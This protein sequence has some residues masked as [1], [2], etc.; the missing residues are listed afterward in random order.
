MY[1]S[2]YQTLDSWRGLAALL[3][4]FHHVSGMEVGRSAVMVFF[5]ISGYCIT[6]SAYSC[7]ERGLGFWGY[8]RR[9]VRRIY[10]PYLLALAY[11]GVTRLI[12][13]W[14]TGQD[15]LSRIT[16]WQWVQNVTLT[17][18]VSL[19]PSPIPR[20]E[21]NYTNLV[22]AFWSLGYEEQ[23]YLLVAVL[24]GV[25]ARWENG[26]T[27]GLLAITAAAAIWFVG[28]GGL[29][30]GWFLDYWL[31][32][33]MGTLSYWRLCRAAPAQQ[34]WIDGAL[35]AVTLIAG[36][37]LVAEIDAEGRPRSAEVFTA[38]LFALVLIGLRRWDAPLHA[39]SFGRWTGALGLVTY[40]L[41]LIHQCNLTLVHQTILLLTPS[42]CPT[43][44]VIGLK[45]GLHV[46]IAFL[47]WWFCKR[48]FLN[49]PMDG[50]PLVPSGTPVQAQE[51]NVG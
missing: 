50:P 28:W 45:I 13:W 2:R 12:K 32:F 47:F 15:D 29:A 20:A 43:S 6:A 4:V 49:R 7:Q 16:P 36:A 23:F 18:W 38:G 27:R 39:S 17:Q 25:S 41:Y 22:A 1:A 42:G 46:A 40:S 24:V 26:L 3:V 33:G 19:L 5:V 8:L 44:V 30:Y 51:G 14:L 31:L 48:P 9:R 35:A 37:L 10:P 34:R 21:E 11:Y